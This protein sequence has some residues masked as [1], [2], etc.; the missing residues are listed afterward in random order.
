MLWFESTLPVT[1]LWNALRWADIII[2]VH[3]Q[4]LWT[5]FELISRRNHQFRIHSPV[6]VDKHGQDQRSVKSRRY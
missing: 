3:A 5:W 1:W 4:F 6:E 2:N